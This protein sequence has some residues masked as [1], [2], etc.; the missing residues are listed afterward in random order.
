MFNVYTNL[1]NKDGYGFKNFNIKSLE[2]LISFFNDNG[3][4]IY[5]RDI[6]HIKLL[7][8]KNAKIYI[9]NDPF[10]KEI[11]DRN[12]IIIAESQYEL[13]E[14]YSKLLMEI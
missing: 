11:Q 1:I 14:M 9:T 3:Y 6:N 8:S 5:D 4:N 7:F 10:A 2:E 12:D 13:E